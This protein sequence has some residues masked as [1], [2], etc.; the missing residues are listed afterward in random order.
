MENGSYLIQPIPALCSSGGF[1]LRCPA[2]HC[3]S[4]CIY[5]KLRLRL[6]LQGDIILAYFTILDSREKNKIFLSTLSYMLG[7]V[8]IVWSMYVAIC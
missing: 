4:V 1:L 3:Q 7:C 5:N 2:H 6:L 8:G